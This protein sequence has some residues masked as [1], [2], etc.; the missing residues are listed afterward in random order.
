MENANGATAMARR[1]QEILLDGMLDTTIFLVADMILNFFSGTHVKTS[2][3]KCLEM[4]CW[5]F[6]FSELQ[7]FF[8]SELQGNVHAVGRF[9]FFRI[10]GN[11]CKAEPDKRLTVQR[12]QLMAIDQ[13]L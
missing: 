10:T 4:C 5:K 12:I 9:L 11:H 7:G 6:F 8:F 1:A 2:M 3:L 13:H